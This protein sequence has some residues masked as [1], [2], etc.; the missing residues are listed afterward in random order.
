MAELQGANCQV[1]DYTRENLVSR[2]TLHAW[3]DCEVNHT[4]RKVKD[5]ARA[6]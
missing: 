1:D 4:G 3:S 6:M 2:N 5:N